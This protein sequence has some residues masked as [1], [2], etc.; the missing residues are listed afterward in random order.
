MVMRGQIF[1]ARNCQ[2]QYIMAI[3]GQIFQ[4]GRPKDSSRDNTLLLWKAK[5][6]RLAG[7]KNLLETIHYGYRRPNIPGWPAKRIC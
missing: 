3:G 7:Q 4:A 1:Q 6:S 5:Y 2:E